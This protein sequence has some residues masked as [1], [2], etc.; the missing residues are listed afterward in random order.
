M[1]IVY[2]IGAN[3][4]DQDRLIKSVLKNADT[5]ADH[6][7]KVP[8]PSK[9]RRLIRETI[10]KLDGALPSAGTREVL[11]DAI[12]DQEHCNRIVM[13]NAKFICIHG[14]VFEKGA[15][16]SQA[17]AK[18]R[19]LRDLFP[20]DELQICLAIRNPATFIPQIVTELKTADLDSV[21]DGVD[22]M[23]LRWSELITRIRAA[24]PDAALTVWCNEDTPLIW[25]QLIRE[26][27]G[28]GPMTRITGG[29]DLLSTILTQD[30]MKKFAT[31]LKANPPQTETQKRKIIAAFMERYA[32]PEEVEDEIDLPGWTQETVNQLTAL[33][34]QDIDLIEKMDGVRFIAP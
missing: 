21:L 10:Q 17:E 15:F 29:F 23:G 4:T 12:I 18:L 30:G 32:I 11:L 6:G 3:C 34:E 25:A 26:M 33:Y 9:Y 14:R 19:G 2:H 28:V 22:P 7:I 8:G 16:Y 13:S 5:F 20:D 31:Y 24:V 1:Q 27:G